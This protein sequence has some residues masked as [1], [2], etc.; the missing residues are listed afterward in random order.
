MCP[1]P[2]VQKDPF[3]SLCPP[4]PTLAREL[5]TEAAGR[6]AAHEGAASLIEARAPLPPDRGTWRLS[7]LIGNFRVCSAMPS[8]EPWGDRLPFS[9]SPASHQALLHPCPDAPPPSLTREARASVAGRLFSLG[10]PLTCRLLRCG[11][12]D[13]PSFLPAVLVWGWPCIFPAH[14]CL[15][16]RPSAPCSHSPTGPRRQA[17]P[18]FLLMEGAVGPCPWG[19]EVGGEKLLGLAGP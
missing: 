3:F 13:L 6:R 17:G 10:A 8:A 4:P 7:A 1:C 14:C 9:P 18:C 11:C 16:L 19:G 15:P 5:I 2:C 12:W